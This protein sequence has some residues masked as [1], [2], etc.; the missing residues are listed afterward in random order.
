[1]NYSPLTHYVRWSGSFL[2]NSNNL[3]SLPKL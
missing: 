3:P 1:V 2:V